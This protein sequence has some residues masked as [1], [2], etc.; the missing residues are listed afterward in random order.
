MPLFDM[1]AWDIEHAPLEHLHPI[2]SRLWRAFAN[3]ELSED[4]AQSLAE[5][6]RDRQR[7][8]PPFKPLPPLQPT[9]AAF[10]RPATIT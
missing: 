2:C 6:A 8:K 7:P 4:E 1:L 3:G 9:G 5:L 10:A